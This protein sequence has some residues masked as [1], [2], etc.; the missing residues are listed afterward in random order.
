MTTKRYKTGVIHGRFQVL[1]KDHLKYLQSGMELCQH[2]VVGI[3]NP[4]PAQS[5][6]ESSDANRGQAAA[7][8]LTYFER[9][10]LLRATL[11]DAGLTFDQFSVV[12][13]PI[14]YPERYQ[15]YVPMDATF[16]LTIYDNWGRQKLDYFKS[17]GLTVHILRDVTPEEK[18][19]SASAVRSLMIEDKNWEDFT[20]KAVTILLKSWDVPSRLKTLKKMEDS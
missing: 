19:I 13:F 18:G 14:N 7:N 9:Y 11:I 10:T 20:P 6:P 4:A 3:T 17:Q 12:P 2:L 5:K 1:H 8:P 16:F 15:Y